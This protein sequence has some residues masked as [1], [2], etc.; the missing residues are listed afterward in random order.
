M[1][2]QSQIPNIEHV[3][4]DAPKMAATGLGVLQQELTTPLLFNRQTIDKFKGRSGGKLSFS[5]P[6]VLP[7]R[8][9]ALRNDRTDPVIFDSIAEAQVDMTVGE[10]IYSGVRITDEQVDFDEVSPQ[11]LAPIQGQAIANGINSKAGAYLASVDY[12][13]VIGGAEANLLQALLEARRV[14]NSFHVPQQG[15]TLLVSSDFEMALLL[16]ERIT[17]ARN[18]GN[19]IA[20]TA[21]KEATIGRVA[22]FSVVVDQTLEAGTAIAFAGDSF[23]MFTG[24]PV[25]PASV[26]VGATASYGGFSLRWIRDYE[27]TRVIDRS[28]MDTYLGFAHAMDFLQ[29]YDETDRLVKTTAEPHFVRAIGLNLTGSNVVNDQEALD[30][31]GVKLATITAPAAA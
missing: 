20:D 2:Y 7:W 3:V 6:G 5:L 28:L 14:L 29:A 9:Y 27:M 4:V 18:S 31:T 12:P 19:A 21:I 26:P 25:V 13:V 8:E 17:L 16:D 1:A 10:R 15:R 24:A 22:G 11:Y 30:F 23:T